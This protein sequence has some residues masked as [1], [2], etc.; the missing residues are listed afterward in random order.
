MKVL[1]L[2][3]LFW[4]MHSLG[5]SWQHLATKELQPALSLEMR[6]LEGSLLHPVKMEG[7][8]ALDQG[9]SSKVAA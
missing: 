6:S 5:A 8:F 4:G 3:F 2:P 7:Q 1:V 9:K